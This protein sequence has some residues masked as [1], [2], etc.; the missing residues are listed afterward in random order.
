MD[1]KRAVVK[2]MHLAGSLVDSMAPTK[3]AQMVDSRALGWAVYLVD[4]M[5]L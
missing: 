1:V 3:E 2:A 4:A 5:V